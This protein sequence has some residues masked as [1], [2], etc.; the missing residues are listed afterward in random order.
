MRKKD[1]FWGIMIASFTA[2]LLSPLASPLPDGLERVAGDLGFFGA[3]GQKPFI[4]AL[5][6]DYQI[7]GV[8]KGISSAIT[9]LVGVLAMF[10]IGWS[11]ASLLKKFRS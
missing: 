9:G 7:P 11:L 4:T 3:G 2:V 10:G 1:I 8:D 5:F 6:P